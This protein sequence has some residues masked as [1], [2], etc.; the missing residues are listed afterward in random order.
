MTL[1]PDVDNTYDIGKEGK[2]WATGRFAN[3]TTNTLT[4]NDLDFG[5]IDPIRNGNIIYVA[6]NG[7]DTKTGTQLQDPARTIAKALELVHWAILF[8]F[9]GQYPRSISN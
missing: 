5:S 6:T 3:V 7:G 8:T 4:T 2:R 1:C 9:I